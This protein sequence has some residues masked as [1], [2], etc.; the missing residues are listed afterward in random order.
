MKSL[1]D[2]KKTVMTSAGKV[3]VCR[4]Y[5]ECKKC[6]HHEYDVDVSLGC[7]G[8]YSRQAMRLISLAGASWGFETAEECLEE[9]TGLKL[10][11]NTINKI[12][13]E[14][15]AEMKTFVRESKYLHDDFSQTVGNTEFTTDGVTVRTTKG[16]REV[17]VGMFVKRP[18]GEPRTAENFEKTP[19]PNPKKKV[20]FAQIVTKKQLAASLPRW[21]KR[22]KIHAP[23]I[24]IYTNTH[25]IFI[26]I[27]FLNYQQINAD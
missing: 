14:V 22:L 16:W 12:A 7:T 23:C 3:D 24:S 19:L 27:H 15:G 9:M 4:V 25:S 2:Y 20:G 21:Q 6:L 13:C 11:P 8:T 18:A 5:F 1:K 26:T 10:S 17:K